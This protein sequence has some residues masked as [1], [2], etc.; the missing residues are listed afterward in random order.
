VGATFSI[1]G[2]PAGQYGIK[3]ATASQYN[4]DLPDVVLSSGEDLTTNIP[5]AGVITVFARVSAPAGHSIYLPVLLKG[6]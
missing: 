3:Y 2:L 5:A 4:V 6:P 1:H